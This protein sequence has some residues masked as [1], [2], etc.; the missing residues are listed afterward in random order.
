MT[1]PDGLEAIAGSTVHPF[2]ERLAAA[3]AL[4]DSSPGPARLARL[5]PVLDGMA[6][7]RPADDLRGRTLVGLLI[8]RVRS[9]RHEF[10]E[11]YDTLRGGVPGWAVLD[12]LEWSAGLD[13]LG[14]LASRTG[15]EADAI[16]LIET[17]EPDAGL[18]PLMRVLAVSSLLAATG[19]NEES[20]DRLRAALE[21]PGLPGPVAG[22]L[23][24]NLGMRLERVGRFHDALAEFERA[25]RLMAGDVRAET[26]GSLSI[27]YLQVGR[28]DDAARTADQ[29]IE[30]ART[31]PNPETL[32]N[33]LLTRG[34]ICVAG[35]QTRLAI[36]YFHSA[37]LAQARG[38]SRAFEIVLHNNI[39][40]C[41]LRLGQAA[42]AVHYLMSALDASVELGDRESR[43]LALGTLAGVSPPAEARTIYTEAYQIYTDLGDVKGQAMMLLGVARCCE[44]LG[45]EGDAIHFLG[46]A[47]DV[48]E[49]VGDPEL[50]APVHAMLGRLTARSGDAE[51]AWEHHEQAWA[52]GETL[53]HLTMAETVRVSLSEDTRDDI[54][55][56]LA[57]ALDQNWTPRFFSMLERN[58]ARTLVDTLASR[59]SP[60][61]QLPVAL[62]EELA[63][64]AAEVRRS[65]ACLA[66]ERGADAGRGAELRRLLATAHQHFK[67]YEGFVA[68][69]SRPYRMLGST[70]P[71]DETALDTMLGPAVGLIEYVA[72]DGRLAGLVRAGGRMTLHQH[73]DLAEVVAMD[74]QLTA[75]CRDLSD[76]DE[77]I[78]LSRRLY[79]RLFAPFE[80]AGVLA[81]VSELVVV[82]A[83]EVFGFPIEALATGDGFVFERY[84]VTYLPAVSVAPFLAESGSSYEPALVLSDPD[85]TLRYARG[86]ADVVRQYFRLV[87]DGE[88][89]LGSR[90]TLAELRASAPSA[91][92]IHLATHAEFDPLAPSFSTIRLAGAPLEVGTLLELDLMPCL[93]VLT[94]CDTGRG[95]ADS[96]NEMIG[97]IRAFT[98]SGAYAVIAS[99][100]AVP[101]AA[102]SE[103]V[104]SFYAA[105]AGGEHPVEALRQARTDQIH[106]NGFRHPGYWAPFTYFGL[107]P[108]ARNSSM[109]VG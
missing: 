63:R 80:A 94:G 30:A 96:V 3:G 53:R 40:M 16:E 62:R 4:I 86:E 8:T 89:V 43:V 64:R 29:A 77:A 22:V 21:T 61:Q 58:R 93:V 107:P 28:L 32:S 20:I 98:V 79:E 6:R 47:L 99:R 11:A 25:R 103:Y 104:R 73:G 91:R 15:R 33:M 100:W 69:S 59:S 56:A 13:L 37:L 57:L 109:P 106:L 23:A 71:I 55:A 74:R 50:R 48:A 90:A 5:L 95:S 83:P 2:E 85:G 42:I 18:W 51:R 97:F 54:A 72:I 19:R 46:L 41:Y 70:E 66:A 12:S 17:T 102:T 105:L 24:R 78:A 76:E 84:S 67:D 52:A 36:N 75:Y 108:S 87:G 35:N 7:D 39:A 49:A 26:L 31:D 9:L 14:A 45:E 44:Q 38:G 34:S 92:L 65:R 81:G 60:A 88:P 68:Q 101:D 1:G 27:G 82:P 10:A